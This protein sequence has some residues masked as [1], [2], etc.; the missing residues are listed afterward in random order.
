MFTR[1]QTSFGT[2]TD[3]K[4]KNS[5][6]HRLKTVHERDHKGPIRTTRLRMKPLSQILFGYNP[7]CF[8]DS[9]H[10]LRIPVGTDESTHHK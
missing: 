5:P 3:N 2:P 7:V 4:K 9:R 10:A 6:L 8:F 1:L